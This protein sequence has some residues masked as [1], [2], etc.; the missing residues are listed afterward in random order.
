[1]NSMKYYVTV[2]RFFISQDK[3]GSGSN[4]KYFDMKRGFK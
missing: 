2:F 4:L 1:M 3:K